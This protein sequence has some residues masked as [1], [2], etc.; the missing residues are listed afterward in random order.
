MKKCVNKND[1]KKKKELEVEIVRL[2]AELEARQTLELDTFQPRRQAEP[3]PIAAE[4]PSPNVILKISHE[5]ERTN[6]GK[7]EHDEAEVTPM[8][9]TLG[10]PK[11]SRAQKRRDKK[12][13]QEREKQK[14]IEQETEVLVENSEWKKED[15]ELER[16]LGDLGL[17]VFDIPADGHW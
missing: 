8:N 7:E 6:L 9:T 14:R 16:I 12:E 1:K 5:L 10:T 15:K 3:E 17:E 11:L 13:S 4:P 2:E